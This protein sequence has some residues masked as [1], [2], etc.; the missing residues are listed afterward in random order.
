[1]VRCVGSQAEPPFPVHVVGAVN[2]FRHAENRIHDDGVARTFGYGAGLV[3]GTTVY[4]YLCYP[5]GS[6]RTARG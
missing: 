5:L 2:Q 3:A 4:A 1:M 6:G